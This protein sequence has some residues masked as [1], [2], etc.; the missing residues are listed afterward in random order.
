MQLVWRFAHDGAPLP[1]E[2]TRLE[3]DWVD[4]A[5]P[6]PAATTDAMAKQAQMGAIPATSDVY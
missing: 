3:V 2:M 5:T 4:P 6:T 1:D